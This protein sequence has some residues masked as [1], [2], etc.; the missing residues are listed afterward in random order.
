MKGWSGEGERQSKAVCDRMN[1]MKD[2]LE[3]GE[4]GSTH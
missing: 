3:V 1:K 4:R 2:G